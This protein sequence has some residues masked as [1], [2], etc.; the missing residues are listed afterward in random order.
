[1]RNDE[2]W[3]GIGMRY[4]SIFMDLGRMSCY[5]FNMEYEWEMV[6]KVGMRFICVINISWLV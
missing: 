4:N 3:H 5:W 2:I 6:N 1:V